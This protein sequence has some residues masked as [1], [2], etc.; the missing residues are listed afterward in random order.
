MRELVFNQAEKEKDAMGRFEIMCEL[1]LYGGEEV[2]ELIL[3][4]LSEE[5]Q[6]VFLQGVGHYHLLTDPTFYKA[7]ERAMGEVIYEEFQARA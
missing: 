1:F 2:R 3:S 5:E 4:F 6:K 7:T